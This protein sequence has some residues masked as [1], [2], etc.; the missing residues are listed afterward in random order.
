MVLMSL[1]IRGQQI[2]MDTEDSKCFREVMGGE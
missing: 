1:Q 2:K